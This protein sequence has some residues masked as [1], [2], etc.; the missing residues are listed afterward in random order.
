MNN[1][2][3]YE[4][5]TILFKFCIEEA[6]KYRTLLTVEVLAVKN[7]EYSK[8]IQHYISTAE[9]ICKMINISQQQSESTT[10]TL[11]N[12]CDAHPLPST[13]TKNYEAD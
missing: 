2:N 11:R 3:E 6:E 10:D 4:L 8:I 9:N 7:Q 5:A 12:V 13:L 1:S